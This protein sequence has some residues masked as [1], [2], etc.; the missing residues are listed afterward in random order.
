MQE[1]HSKLQSTAIYKQSI[2]PSSVHVQRYIYV[3]AVSVA[4]FTVTACFQRVTAEN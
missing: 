2:D 4:L 1:V 3:K